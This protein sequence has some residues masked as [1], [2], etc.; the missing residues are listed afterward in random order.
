MWPTYDIAGGE[1]LHRPVRLIRR[2]C[3]RVI[4]DAAASGQSALSSDANKLDLCSSIQPGIHTRLLQQALARHHHTLQFHKDDFE[5][6]GEDLPHAYR[7]VPVRPNDSWAFLVAYCITHSVEC[8][9]YY[10]LLFGLPLAATSF[11]R[12]PRFLQS[13]FRR[14]GVVLCSMYFDDLT[15]QDLRSSKGSAQWFCCRLATLLGSP[16]SEEKH[17]AMA[18]EGDFLGYTV[19]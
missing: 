17:Q 8:R 14:L 4:D 6:G 18:P 11:N 13:L 12:W 7:S 9:R 16:F 19:V 1:F 10:G 5:T 3:I 2:F 15:V